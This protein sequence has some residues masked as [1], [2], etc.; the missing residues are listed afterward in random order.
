[1]TRDDPPEWLHL[2]MEQ[3]FLPRARSPNLL[4]REM[5][6]ALPGGMPYYRV[7]L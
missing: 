1:M 6:G 3:L 5:R 4:P 7:D 2:V